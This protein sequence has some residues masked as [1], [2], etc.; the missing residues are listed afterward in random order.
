MEEKEAENIGAQASGANNDN[1][2]GV[3]D[4]CSGVPGMVS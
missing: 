1:Q 2:L 4:L 3:G